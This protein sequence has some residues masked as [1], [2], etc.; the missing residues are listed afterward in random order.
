[1]IL[2]KVSSR[3]ETAIPALLGTFVSKHMLVNVVE[4]TSV[5]LIEL[6]I[7]SLNELCKRG[8]NFLGFKLGSNVNIQRH[9]LEG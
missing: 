6:W 9:K 4:V 7:E 8:C 2:A 5:K 1:M 3:L